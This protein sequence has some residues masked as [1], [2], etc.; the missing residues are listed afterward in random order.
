MDTHHHHLREHQRKDGSTEPIVLVR[1]NTSKSL[2]TRREQTTEADLQIRYRTLSI[3]VGEVRPQP[4]PVP[5]KDPAQALREIDVH[6]LRIEDVF[7][8]YS[9]HPRLGLDNAAVKR[10]AAH[11]R[12][13]ISPAPTHYWKQILLYVFGG[14]NFLLWVACI[15]SFI[16]WKPLG[17]PN[18]QIINLGV[19]VLL[20]VIIFISAG[21]YAFVDWNASRIMKSV[22]GMM[23]ETA[24]VIREG[25]RQDIPADGLVVGDVVCLAL[26]QRVPADLRIVE[27]STDLKFDRSLMTGESDPVA[28]SITPSET[29]PLQ[30]RNL[31]LSSTFVVQ[32]N[33]VGVVFAIGDQSIMGRIVAM[34]GKQK[35]EMT[36]IQKEIN[37]FTLI[38]S[39]LAAFFFVVSMLTW[40]FWLRVSYPG[41]MTLSGALLNAI[42]CLTAFV[43]AGLPVCVALS[44]TVVARRMASRKVLVKNLATI[45]T[46]GCMSVLCSDKTGTLTMAKMYVEGVAFLD[47]EMSSSPEKNVVASVLQHKASADLRL[48]ALLCNGASFD[49]TTMNLA[50]PDRL[51]KGDS[52]DSSILR[53]GETVGPI[54]EL[55]PQY[56]KLFEIPFNSKNKW[57]LTIVRPI[58]SDTVLLL[59]KGAP[60]I[61]IRSCTKVIKADGTV[62]QI[63][64]DT[65]SVVDSIQEKWSTKGHRVLALCRRELQFSHLPPAEELENF[66]YGMIS[67]LTLVGMLGICDP[68][69]LDVK[70]SIETM[71][72]AGVRVFMVTGDFRLTA[73]AIARQVGIVTAEATHTIEKVRADENARVRC[74]ALELHDM[75]PDTSCPPC[76]IVITGDD[77]ANITNDE[78]NVI[79]TDYAE[80]V[81]ARTTPEQK[82]RIVNEAKRRGDNTV[83][84][85]GDGVNDGP[86]LKAADIGIAM[87]AGSDV[88]KEAA[89]MVLLNNDFSSILVAIENGR[90]VFDNLKK[91][92][93]YLMP[94]GSYTEFMAV[95]AN[96]FFGI[97]QPMTTFQQIIICSMNDV[98][99]AIG[100]MYEI[101]ESDLMLRKPRNARTE[102]L[103]DWRF[104]IQ[105]YLFTGGIMWPACMFLFFHYFAERG[106]G[107]Y[108][109]I[110]M[111]D[112]WG[113]PGTASGVYDAVTL[114]SMLQSAQAC[115]FLCMIGMQVFN[116]LATR[117]RRVSMFES[118]P[119]WGPHKNH[120][121]LGSVVATYTIAVIVVQAPGIQTVFLTAAVPIK[122][123]FI[124]LGFG[125]GLFI[126]DEIR[127]LI[128]RTYPKSIVAKIAW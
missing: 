127:K 102:R 113:A 86:A 20:L 3:H 41:Y 126:L 108:D 89:V 50:I 52:T 12:N 16:S 4:G 84:V 88:A 83:A 122:Y 118:N 100:L 36:T 79:F 121:F 6:L 28:G 43:P 85:T 106:I 54:S 107:F 51:I 38:I 5:S 60:D 56:E 87:G 120:A 33:G 44:L 105:V 48:V 68:P 115:Y 8:K 99:M 67:D 58:N 82:L 1:T 125:A 64:T 104:F 47:A 124:P 25:V 15:V 57:M 91:V 103:T 19:A 119:F 90:L 26:G 55:T 62:V 94:A 35:L 77:M 65:R 17:E 123:W 31:A 93:L 92:V 2:R 80:I 76:S 112:K 78:W 109:V 66:C 75:K 110:F 96:F 128:A 42:G 117:N 114:Q 98:A 23:A 11:G 53:F 14:F 45:E 34:S 18:P 116:F 59:I 81:F 22:N 37:F 29:N 40:A 111:F 95:A 39:G 30:T 7:T 13:V 32:G 97:Q 49:A 27:M 69:R 71:R 10:K 63:D 24:T 9:T 73:V 61:M 101:A 21:F 74:A 46:L 72:R 70:P